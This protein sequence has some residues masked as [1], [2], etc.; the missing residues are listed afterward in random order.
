MI[1]VKCE[2]EVKAQKT[3]AMKLLRLPK[4]RKEIAASPD[5]AVAVKRF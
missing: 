5:K 4:M 3:P 1:L 2:V